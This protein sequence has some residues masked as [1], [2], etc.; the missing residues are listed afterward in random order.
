MAHTQKYTMPELSMAWHLT[1]ALLDMDLLE[2]DL[3]NHVLHN[4]HR[5]QEGSRLSGTSKSKKK[6]PL[7][8]GAPLILT[9]LVY[10]ALGVIHHLPPPLTYDARIPFYQRPNIMR[11]PVKKVEKE[12]KQARKREDVETTSSKE[13]PPLKER[14]RGSIP[15]EQAPAPP[16]GPPTQAAPRRESR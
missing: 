11:S 1:G 4:I 10:Y 8:L 15:A 2:V 7:A 12:G 14:I 9:R 6:L 16:S 3:S 13:V 5:I